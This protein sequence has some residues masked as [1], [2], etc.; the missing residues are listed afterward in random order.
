MQGIGKPYRHVMGSQARKVSDRSFWRVCSM[1]SSRGG[2]E[3][4]RLARSM[5][6]APAEV[7]SVSAC[8]MSRM[9]VENK[10][11]NKPPRGHVGYHVHAF[12][13][14]SEEICQAQGQKK[15]REM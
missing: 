5:G 3:D 14:I 10:Q 12:S 7:A 6:H 15:C 13:K 2:D 9:A 4:R 1:D 8:S 11:T